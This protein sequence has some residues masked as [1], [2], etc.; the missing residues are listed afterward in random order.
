M[1]RLERKAKWLVPAALV[2]TAS[3]GCSPAPCGS[4][5]Y[6][7]CWPDGGFACPS[8]CGAKRYADG[9]LELDSMGMP[10][11]LC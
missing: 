5:P 9:G 11:C 1:K 2:A 3:S 8:N 10:D 6:H 4:E 7:A